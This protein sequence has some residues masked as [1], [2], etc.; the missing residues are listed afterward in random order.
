MVVTSRGFKAGVPRLAW[1]GRGRRMFLRHVGVC[2][3][4][5]HEACLAESQESAAVEI[6]VIVEAATLPACGAGPTAG[7]RLAAV[8]RDDDPLELE[9]VAFADLFDR[10]L[11]GPAGGST[12][13]RLLT[14]R[15]AELQRLLPLHVQVRSFA[16]AANPRR[17]R[18]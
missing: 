3:V 6:A 1:D 15:A 8:L 12:S 18:P 9:Q 14:A 4:P 11:V 10:G 17:T 5:S 16:P 2:P 7:D 13:T